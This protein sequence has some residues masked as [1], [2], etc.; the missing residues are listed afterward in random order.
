[1]P[2]Y[3]AWE[4]R[5]ARA[6][7][8]SAGSEVKSAL[9]L[10]SALPGWDCS[11]IRL[12]ATCLRT[13][14]STSSLVNPPPSTC[15]PQHYLSS[16][17]SAHT[18]CKPGPGV[19]IGNNQHPHFRSCCFQVCPDHPLPHLTA[20]KIPVYVPRAPSLATPSW[21]CAALIHPQCNRTNCSSM[22]PSS[23]MG[24][25]G[26]SGTGRARLEGRCQGAA[27][28]RTGTHTQPLTRRCPP[29]AAAPPAALATP[30]PPQRVPFVS[31]TLLC[32]TKPFSALMQL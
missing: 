21:D 7:R 12:C 17:K 16:I 31:V 2:F 4:A 29:G 24:R 11:C 30:A 5:A 19:A 14:S 22:D 10:P 3:A 20:S 32:M 26:A 6:L 1:M 27:A 28:G 9:T 18:Q 23:R 15:R 25:P 13:A 8:W